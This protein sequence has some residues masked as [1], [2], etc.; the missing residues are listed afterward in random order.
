MFWGTGMQQLLKDSDRLAQ[1]CLAE[2][3]PVTPVLTCQDPHR[4]RCLDGQARL[5]PDLPCQSDPSHSRVWHAQ[6]PH[7]E[8]CL[9]VAGLGI[10]VL[11]VLHRE[12]LHSDL[13][14]QEVPGHSCA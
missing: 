12:G 6:D 3:I 2:K 7:R 5:H 11:N 14:C 10:H 9:E 4:E 13:P 8:G 1:T